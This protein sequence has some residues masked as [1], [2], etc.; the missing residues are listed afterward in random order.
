MAREAIKARCASAA[1]GVDLADDAFSA[2]RGVLRFDDAASEFMAGDSAILHVAARRFSR[3]VPQMPA[4][5]T[6]TILSPGGCD[7]VGVVG[8]EFE[9]AIEDQR[10]HRCERL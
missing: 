5:E 2:E 4:V 10:A 1:S 6:R 3:S 9:V 7:G 8:A